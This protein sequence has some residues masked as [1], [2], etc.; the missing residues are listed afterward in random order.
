MRDIADVDFGPLAAV[1]LPREADG[2]FRA[3]HWIGG[4][5][6]PGA[7]RFDDLDPAT[8]LRLATVSRGDAET[9]D[10][11][12]RAAS[13]ALS[14]PWAR[15]S[16]AERADLLDALASFV[17]THRSALSAIECLD[18]GKPWVA[19]DERDV[20]RVIDNLRFFAGAVRHDQ[21]ALFQGEGV[22][23]FELRRP[24]GVVA[25]ITP[26]NLPL[27]LLSWKLAPALAMGNTVVAKPSDLSPLSATWLAAA[28]SQLGLPPGVFNVVH[29]YG[30]EV[31]EALVNHPRVAG[32]SF[33]GGT[34]T[35]SRIAAAAA[36]KFKKY[37]LE[38]GGKNPTLV[39]ADADL[40]RAAA[41]AARA[42]FSN[43]GQ[44]CLCGS[45]VLVERSVAEVFTERLIHHAKAWEP[46]DPRR[47]DTRFGSLI[48]AAHREKVEGY[49][50]LA[51][52]H[53]GRI[54]CGGDRP[55]ALPAA[56]AFLRPAVITD[57]P[58]DSSCV[59]EEVFGPVLTVHPFDGEREAIELANAVRYGLAASLWT[60]DLGR[61]HRVAAALHAGV[62]WVNCWLVRDLRVAFGGQKDSGVGREGGR[63]ALEFYSETSSVCVAYGA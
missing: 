49:L 28:A 30:S 15:W 46:A 36:P 29:G 61:G 34:A 13:D 39:F 12:A 8:G 3:D 54:R 60:R 24:L 51:T 25:L 27:Q 56:G 42:A 47:R 2:T 20:Q 45:R 44:I 62:V 55:S 1:G 48:S 9:V 23:H 6:H 57:L 10:S 63:H 19:A 53:G 5:A 43:Q 14:G 16:V 35:G 41:E 11:A 38:L 59:Q 7:V 31:G 50:R 37:C 17:Q 52:A 33:T 58:H 32:I 40:E 22:L 26:W 18:T 21:Q 4:T